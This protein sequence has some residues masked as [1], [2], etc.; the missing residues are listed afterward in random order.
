[1][2]DA[3]ERGATPVTGV[4]EAA[5]TAPGHGRGDR[6]LIDGVS[7]R[8]T[9]WCS[10]S[11][12]GRRRRSGGWPCRRCSGRGAR[13]SCWRP[14]CRPGR[15]QRVPQPG[16]P[17]EHLEI[18]PRPGGAVYVNGP[19]EHG[20]LPD[21]PDEIVPSEPSGE[22]LHRRAGVHSSALRDAEVI[23]RGSLLPAADRRRHPPDRPGAGRAGAFLAT[24]H[25]SWGILNAPATGRMVSRDD[26]RRRLALAR[27]EP[28]ALTRLPGRPHRR[29]RPGPSAPTRRTRA[30]RRGRRCGPM[31][32]VVAV[33]IDGK[34]FPS[35]D[36][37]RIRKVVDM[38]VGAT[39]LVAHGF[40]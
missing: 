33:A 24:A 37:P 18:Y 17:A 28:F 30:L 40:G 38:T 1:M 8:P 26:P 10:R 19:P 32:V 2:E 14:T 7:S 3:V 12:R 4:V 15:V 31:S 34:D 35:R 9:S 25:A 13:A 36:S 6:R 23:A 16:R 5:S 20:A 27:R 22:E 11:G 39:Y 29:A 21:D